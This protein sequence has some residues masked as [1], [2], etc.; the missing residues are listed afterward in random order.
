LLITRL[1]GKSGVGPAST[2]AVIEVIINEE[3]A[4]NKESNSVNFLEVHS[5]KT[6]YNICEWFH[7][8]VEGKVN[9]VNAVQVGW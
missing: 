3:H 2:L 6:A 9:E 7:N 8:V 4:R 5:E 1:E